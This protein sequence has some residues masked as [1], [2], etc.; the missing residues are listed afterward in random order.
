MVSVEINIVQE[1]NEYVRNVFYIKLTSKCSC[2]CSSG[3][4]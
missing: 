3:T 2:L 4:S 1:E